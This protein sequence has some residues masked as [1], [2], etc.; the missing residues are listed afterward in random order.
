M[1]YFSEVDIIVCFNAMF[2]ALI[3][4]FTLNNELVI[5]ILNLARFLKSKI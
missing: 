1:K 4:A 2:S 5:Q 3:I